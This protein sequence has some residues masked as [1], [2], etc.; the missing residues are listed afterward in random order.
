MYTFRYQRVEHTTFSL[1]MA[2]AIARCRILFMV[3]W[4]LWLVAPVCEHNNNKNEKTGNNDDSAATMMTMPEAK[5]P[6]WKINPNARFSGLVWLYSHV[7]QV[8]CVLVWGVGRGPPGREYE[9]CG[10]RSDTQ[11]KL[12]DGAA[13]TSIYAC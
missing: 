5:N 9:L 6:K 3:E 11:Q 10:K 1:K 12:V 7:M 4:N 2:G 13:S 8:V